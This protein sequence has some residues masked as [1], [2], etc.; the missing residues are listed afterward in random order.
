MDV[1]CSSLFVE[2]SA[3]EQAG[4]VVRKLQQCCVVL[5]FDDP[6]A[7]VKSKEVKRA[8]LN[9]LVSCLNDTKGLL[10]EAVCADIVHMVRRR[11]L[12]IMRIRPNKR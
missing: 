8:T 2:T 7:D 5:S 6:L 3:A 11:V 4:L 9:E 12:Y 1:S 10:T